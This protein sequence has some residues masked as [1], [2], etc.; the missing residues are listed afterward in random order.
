MKALTGDR[1]AR[2]CAGLADSTRECLDFAKVGDRERSRVRLLIEPD[3]GRGRSCTSSICAS[4]A[5]TG[6]S[7]SIADEAASSKTAFAEGD[8][9]MLFSSIIESS[10]SS[11]SS[12]TCS[13]STDL[14]V[15][16]AAF[17]PPNAIRLFS[18]IAD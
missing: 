6:R 10:S 4:G 17:S 15:G 5:E 2:S 8:G 11:S 3:L 7:T 12:R 14:K 16:S 13:Q 1:E 9:A 18:N